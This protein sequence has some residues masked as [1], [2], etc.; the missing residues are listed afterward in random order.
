[1]TFKVLKGFEVETPSGT[2][3]LKEGQ[4]VRLSNEEAIPLLNE[5]KITS[6]EK[7]ACKVYS[8]LLETYLW[9]V[10]TDQDMG[11]LKSQ[12]VSEAIYSHDEI[13]K[14]KGLSKDSLKEIHKVKE[15]FEDSKIEEIKR[16]RDL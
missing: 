15:V 1:M 11:N 7:V 10:D 5:G 13:R 4:R 12:G 14:L 8:E 9:V 2:V 3:T 6:I 16:D